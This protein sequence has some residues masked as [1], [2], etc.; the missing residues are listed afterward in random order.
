MPDDSGGRPFRTAIWRRLRTDFHAHPRTCRLSPLARDLMLQAIE[1]NMAGILE[2]SIAKLALIA[3]GKTTA[4]DV[5]DAISELCDSYPPNATWW[6]DLEIL[7]I[8]E[9][10][11]EQAVNE[12][13]WKSIWKTL[14]AWPDAVFL[15]FHARYSARVPLAMVEKIE[16]RLTMANGGMDEQANG[17]ESE[18]APEPAMDVDPPSMA[19]PKPKKCEPKDVAQVLDA[20]D[21]ERRKSGV[22]NARRRKPAPPST[23]KAVRARISE[24]GLERVMRVV[25]LKGEECR[26]Q[27]TAMI[28]GNQTPTVRF[29]TATSLMRP[30]NFARMDE[31]DELDGVTAADNDEAIEFR[32]ERDGILRALTRLGWRRATDAECEQYEV[33]R[34]QQ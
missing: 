16:K 5:K 28:N 24:V 9:A 26:R 17:S 21:D 31:A 12:N 13:A 33:C 27:R 3:G 32:M 29:L 2:R 34:S 8:C 6:S 4:R 15:A 11:S 1:A 7:W 20:I 19:D 25:R 30:D 18:A 10:A 22:P 23:I 14:M